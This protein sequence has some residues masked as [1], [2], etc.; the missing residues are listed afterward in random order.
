MKPILYLTLA[1]FLSNGCIVTVK[2]KYKP[3]P[4][5]LPENPRNL[6]LKIEFETYHAGI[7]YQPPA[8]ILSSHVQTKDKIRLL[9]Y[10]SKQFNDVILDN[11]DSAELKPDQYKLYLKIK[12]SQPLPYDTY[13]FLGIMG[14]STFMLIPVWETIEHEYE[15]TLYDHKNNM[16]HNYKNHNKVR[17]YYHLLFLPFTFTLY[18]SKYINKNQFI[19]ILS[20]I[21]PHM[22]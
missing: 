20:N 14:G 9:F 1:L 8:H 19:D 21:S 22:T 11:H 2:K 4:S 15:A 6:V 5:S 13:K 10:K 3:V 18:K 17:S 7:K 12:K 16:V